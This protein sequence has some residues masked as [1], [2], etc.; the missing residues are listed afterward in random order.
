MN[1]LRS[2][3]GFLTILPIA[4]RCTAEDL[5]ACPTENFGPNQ[6]WS[7]LITGTRC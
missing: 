2:A 1:G 5:G 7:D 3:I 6:L 4:P